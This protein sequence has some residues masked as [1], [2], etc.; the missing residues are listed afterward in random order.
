MK[1]ILII[2]YLGELRRYR[3]VFTTCPFSITLEPCLKTGCK[4]KTLLSAAYGA[5]TAFP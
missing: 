2:V 4:K 1:I 5:P 3:G